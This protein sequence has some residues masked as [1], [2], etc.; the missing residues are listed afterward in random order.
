MRTSEAGIAEIKQAEGYR[1]FAYPDIASKLYKTYPRAGWG[2]KSAALVLAKLPASASQLSGKPW[3]VGFGQ[4][5]GVTPSTYMNEAAAEDNIRAKL[6]TYEQA[7]L[8]SCKVKPTQGQFDALV[9]IAW[10][11]MSAVRPTSSII[12]AHNRRDWAAASRAFR[13]YNMA[14]G[15]VEDGLIARRQREGL[16]YLNASPIE[17]SGIAEPIQTPEA[18]PERPLAKSQINIASTA[19]GGTAAVAAVSETVNSIAAV[20]MGVSELADWAVPI[21]L[22]AVV[23]LCIYIVMQRNKQRKGGW[24]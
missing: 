19:A 7:V 14:K 11:V 24:A 18:D 17:H 21:L 6:G 2:F 1:A 4:T 3:T 13:L 22:I 16:M 10:N 12:K 9:S 23:A 8:A 15:V 5:V 20:K